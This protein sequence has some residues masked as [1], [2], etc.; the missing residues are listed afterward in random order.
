MLAEFE[1]FDYFSCGHARTP[2]SRAKKLKEDK[3]KRAEK[4]FQ[5]FWE[6]RSGSQGILVILIMMELNLDVVYLQKTQS[7]SMNWM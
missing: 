2:S 6:S 1:L 7:L 4:M 3:E 5:Q